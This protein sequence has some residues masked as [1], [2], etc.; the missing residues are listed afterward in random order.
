LLQQQHNAFL[1]DVHAA[2]FDWW[3]RKLGVSVHSL[4]RLE[5]GWSN[6]SP[7]GITFPVRTP[8]GD[9]CGISVRSIVGSKR[10]VSGSSLNGLFVPNGLDKQRV[11][12]L[13]EG[14][15]DTAA[16]LSIGL[17]AAGRPSTATRPEVVRRFVM[18]HGF[19]RVVVVADRDAH[20]AGQAAA[21][22][23]VQYLGHFVRCALLLPP[24]K[25]VRQWISQGA[26]RDEIVKGIQHVD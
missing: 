21:K 24:V 16:L 20:G 12:F 17:Q 11:L 4:R 1:A 8:A 13:P 23:L 19:Q 7:T 2:Q 14:A 9:I 18:R 10:C 5:M 3:A 26:G 15:S 25:D 6:C 22:A